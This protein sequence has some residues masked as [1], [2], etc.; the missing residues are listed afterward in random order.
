[1]TLDFSPLH[2][3]E[4][5]FD[6]PEAPA[7]VTV[8]EAAALAG[9][10]TRSVRQWCR[11]G[12]VPRRSD[13][14]G[15]VLVDANAVRDVAPSASILRVELDAARNE[16]TNLEHELR[17]ARTEAA[18]QRLHAES[19]NAEAVVLA[20]T[21]ER[22]QADLE[23]LRRQHSFATIS[24]TDWVQQATA[25]YRGPVRE[26][27]PFPEVAPPP[28]EQDFVF[29]PPT[30]RTWVEP[31]ITLPDDPVIDLGEA[32]VAGLDEIVGGEAPAPPRLVFGAS[33]D[34]LLP[35]TETSRRTRR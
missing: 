18:A 5:H 20:A 16:I 23:E 17:V 22:L 7:W 6:A 27:Q 4:R 29:V 1:M 34:D 10:T 12:L 24:S 13:L 35:V 33:P 14:Q 2:S 3:V 11:A 9:V 26:Q 19:A 15:H 25:G 21:V 28:A 31:V 8:T 32:S 30:G